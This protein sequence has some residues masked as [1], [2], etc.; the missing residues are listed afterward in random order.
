MAPRN[1]L[2][3][4]SYSIFASIVISFLIQAVPVHAQT[5]AFF[6]FELHRNIDV[7]RRH[8]RTLRRTRAN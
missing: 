8:R 3:G 7:N 4:F 2:I 5:L 1:S 6:H